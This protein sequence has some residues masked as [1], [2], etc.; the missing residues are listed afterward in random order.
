[1]RRQP[2]KK[3]RGCSQIRRQDKKNRP[4]AR[5]PADQQEIAISMVS[6][7]RR[8]AVISG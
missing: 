3:L 8:W 4:T 5:C 6:G 2:T 1:M 7:I